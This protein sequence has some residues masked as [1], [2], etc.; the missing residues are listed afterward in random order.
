[1]NR[2]LAET[3]DKIL[4]ILS[5]KK[6]IL[7]D[8]SAVQSI[9]SSKMLMNEVNEKQIAAKITEKQIDNSRLAYKP[10]A[11]HASLL[12]FT[13]G[14]VKHRNDQRKRLIIYYSDL[15]LN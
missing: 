12:Y 10:I 6:N 7:E 4:E 14:N 13:I 15:Y 5:T 9:C 1:M 2:I 3:E 11:V 8:E